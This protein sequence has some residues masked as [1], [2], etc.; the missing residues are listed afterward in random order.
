MMYHVGMDVYNALLVMEAIISMY[1]GEGM[2]V[3]PGMETM[4]IIKA[5]RKSHERDCKSKTFSERNVVFLAQ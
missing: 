5:T 1:V 3:S 2:T 4:Q